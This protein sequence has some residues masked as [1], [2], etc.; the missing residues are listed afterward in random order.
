MT[1]RE[2]IAEYNPEAILFDELD[3]AIIGVGQ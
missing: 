3:D 2:Q 1:I